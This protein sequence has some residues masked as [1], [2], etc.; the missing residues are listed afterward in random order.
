MSLV[1]EIF[2]HVGQ[3]PFIL[4]SQY[5][6]CWWPNNERSQGISSHGIDL[7]LQEY[8]NVSTTRVNPMLY[9]HYSNDTKQDH[10]TIYHSF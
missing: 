6:G 3:G 2:P 5:H 10:K 1:V 7:I 9:L 4:H 8:F